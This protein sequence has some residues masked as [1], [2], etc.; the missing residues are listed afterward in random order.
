LADRICQ[1]QWGQCANEYLHLR[2]RRRRSNSGLNLVNRTSHSS[3]SIWESSQKVFFLLQAGYKW[4]ILFYI[5]LLLG[6]SCYY[7]VTG[8]VYGYYSITVHVSKTE[9]GVGFSEESPHWQVPHKCR[10]S[11]APFT[12]NAALAYS[13]A[14]RICSVRRLRICFPF[15][16]S[17][18]CHLF[19]NVISSEAIYKDIYIYTMRGLGVN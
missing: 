3:T 16:L 6:T 12:V 8:Q 2:L 19:I 10:A 1:S 13:A 7:T 14:R 15:F 18:P 4:P 9:L 17:M 11:A 5:I